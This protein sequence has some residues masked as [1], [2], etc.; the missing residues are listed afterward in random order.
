[1]QQRP[2]LEP[3]RRVADCPY[4]LFED[5]SYPSLKWESSL[6]G[7]W[8]PRGFTINENQSFFHGTDVN[9]VTAV[10]DPPLISKSYCEMELIAGISH[11]C[12]YDSSLGKYVTFGV[13]NAGTVWEGDLE[14]HPE[15]KFDLIISCEGGGFRETT[16]YEK[17]AS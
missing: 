5:I 11:V 9:V 17:G 3:V 12:F 14:V 16:P 1:M 8:G 13:I 6:C 4:Q 2:Y 7:N 15:R 10:A